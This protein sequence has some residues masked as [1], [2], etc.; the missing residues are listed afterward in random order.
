MNLNDLQLTPEQ[1]LEFHK[2]LKIGVY[3]ELHKKNL[4]TDFQLSQLIS[5]QF[6]QI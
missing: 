3:K 2:Y 6:N 1:T 5:I 4:L